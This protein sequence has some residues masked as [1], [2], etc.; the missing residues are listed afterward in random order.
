[1]SAY[2]EVGIVNFFFSPQEIVCAGIDLLSSERALLYYLSVDL[3]V[4]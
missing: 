4:C 2:L 3:F 1:M